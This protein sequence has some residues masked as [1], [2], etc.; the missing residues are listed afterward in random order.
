MQN[1]DLLIA[2]GLSFTFTEWKFYSSLQILVILIKVI[3]GHRLTGWKDR[4]I[5]SIPQATSQ[6]EPVLLK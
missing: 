1:W 2:G 5:K 3:A 6:A 4:S